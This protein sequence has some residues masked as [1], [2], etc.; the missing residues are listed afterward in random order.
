MNFE[1][2][3]LKTLLIASLAGNLFLV[4]LGVGV[5][6]M[7]WRMVNN[8]PP[9][10]RSNVWQ[11]STVLSPQDRANMRQVM[12]AHAVEATPDMRAARQARREASSLMMAPVYDGNAVAAALAK[13]READMAAR[14]KMD[15][16]LVAYTATLDPQRR[17][18]LVQAMQA[19]ARNMMRGRGGPRGGGGRGG[20]DGDRDHDRGPGG[21]GE[22]LPPAA[23]APA[24]PK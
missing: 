16:G 6:V 1:G 18:V 24:Q 20:P 11:A 2:P 15:A 22:G 21:P 9:Q 23:A 5:G 12:Q 7:G 10:Q 8:R 13:A 14:A 4:G 3:G 19:D 17:T